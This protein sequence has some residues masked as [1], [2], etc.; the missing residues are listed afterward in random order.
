MAN[1]SAIQHTLLITP[2]GV[3]ALTGKL[4]GSPLQFWGKR[5]QKFTKDTGWAT[6][7]MLWNEQ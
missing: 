1:G 3:E 2:T 4:E 6:H 7:Q 5:I